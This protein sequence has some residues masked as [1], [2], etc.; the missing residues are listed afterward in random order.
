MKLAV[1]INAKAIVEIPDGEY[2]LK[3]K[4]SSVTDSQR[5]R[6]NFTIL[7]DGPRKGWTVPMSVPM[8][9]KDE[10]SELTDMVRELVGALLGPDA[11]L[12]DT[13]QLTDKTM[14]A[15]VRTNRSGLYDVF[16]RRARK[17]SDAAEATPPADDAPVTE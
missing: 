6:V 8:F 11:T 7:S 12:E 9:S 2:D 10:P 13:D 15:Y 16:P 14:R 17:Q 3:V 5:L 1:S 4:S